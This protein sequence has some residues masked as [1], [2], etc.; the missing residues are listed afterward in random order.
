MEMKTLERMKTHGGAVGSLRI[1]EHSQEGS[2]EGTLAAAKTHYYGQTQEKS[3]TS[4]SAV[5]EWK[6][7]SDTFYSSIIQSNSQQDEEEI[8][9]KFEMALA[10]E[11]MKKLQK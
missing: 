11:R 3:V 8:E 6:K 2:E 5:S 1:E 4:Y 9:R 7:A 10:R